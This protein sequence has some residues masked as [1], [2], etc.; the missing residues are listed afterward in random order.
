M[1]SILFARKVNGKRLIGQ[2][3]PDLSMVRQFEGEGDTVDME[4]MVY[5]MVIYQ[6][7]STRKPQMNGEE[8]AQRN[9]P[10]EYRRRLIF[11]RTQYN[12]ARCDKSTEGSGDDQEQ[13]PWAPS[14]RDQIRTQRLKGM[15]ASDVAS[16]AILCS[17]R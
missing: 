15:R 4:K 7:S 11:P 17:P 13:F 5:V 1:K 14:P 2:T 3:N 8:T 9:R 10:C 16:F 6:S 12:P